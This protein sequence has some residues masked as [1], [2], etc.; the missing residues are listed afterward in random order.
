VIAGKGEE[1][2]GARR[3]FGD[4]RLIKLDE[5]GHERLRHVDRVSTAFT[6]TLGA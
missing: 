2:L 3:A 5:D 1:L 6:V 4:P